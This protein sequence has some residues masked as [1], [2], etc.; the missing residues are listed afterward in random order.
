MHSFLENFGLLAIFFVVVYGYK[1]ILEHYDW[2][3]MGLHENKRVYQAADEFVHGARTEDVK[4]ILDTCFEFDE[5]DVEK[6]LSGA[7]PHRTDKDGGYRAFIR[8]VN[9][10]VGDEL[11]DER[12]RTH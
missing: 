4:A 2:K 7:I 1:K 6:I 8:S 12:C 5:E 3:R 10:A 11:Y 9:K